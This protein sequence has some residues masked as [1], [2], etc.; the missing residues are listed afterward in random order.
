MANAKGNPENL[1]PVRTKDEA[2]KRGAAG[3]KKS[4]DSRRKKRDAKQAISLL[5]NMAAKENIEKNLKQLGYNAEDLTNMNALMARLF[6][7]AMTGDVAAFKALMDYGGF[8]PDQEL[9]DKER[10]A[11][12]TALEDGGGY[13]DPDGDD[14]DKEDVIIYLPDNGKEVPE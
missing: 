2:K 3:G 4:G 11:R 6:T 14:E 9:R 8:H 7:K 10:R 1:K 13:P 12:I 5:L